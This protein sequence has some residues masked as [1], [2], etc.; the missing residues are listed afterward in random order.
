MNPIWVSIKN[1]P[2]DPS[3]S[4]QTQ[5]FWHSHPF[6]RTNKS[7]LWASELTK[8]WENIKWVKNKNESLLL[9]FAERKIETWL[10]WWARVEI[11]FVFGDLISS[12]S[13]VNLDLDLNW[14]G[15]RA[16]QFANAEGCLS[17]VVIQLLISVLEFII[18]KLLFF[19]RA[20]TWVCFQIQIR[21][22]KWRDFYF[23]PNNATPSQFSHAF[24]ISIPHI[25]TL[26][27]SSHS[28]TLIIRAFSS[29]R[30]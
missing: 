22:E 17:V 11:I 21:L 12:K 3:I 20:T 6:T 2:H 26:L 16:L 18:I 25:S 14:R 9:F 5:Y 27:P 28:I 23:K 10:I 1:A 24:L 4:F 29:V 15:E 30:V 19:R 13:S 7:G 8:I